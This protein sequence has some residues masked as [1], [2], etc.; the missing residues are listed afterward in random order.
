MNIWGCFCFLVI[1]DNSSMYIHVLV[2]CG[3][4]FNSFGHIRRSGIAKSYDYSVFNFLRNCQTVFQSGCTIFSCQQHESSNFSTSLPMF[5]IVFLFFVVIS[6]LA[7]VKWYL[8]VVLICISLMTNNFEHLFVC[9]LFIC[10]SSLEKCL[11]KF[12]AHF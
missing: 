4:V 10:I 3:H 9:L 5:V 1:M 7:G 11:F 6:I 8:I 12:F 2:L